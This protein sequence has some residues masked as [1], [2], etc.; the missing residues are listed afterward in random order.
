[1]TWWGIERRNRRVVLTLCF[2]DG[3]WYF[4]PMSPWGR[5]T[6]DG[7]DAEEGPPGIIAGPAP[8]HEEESRGG[9]MGVGDG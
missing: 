9:P 2:N 6:A 1:M 3:R 7:K 5:Q 8:V 4:N